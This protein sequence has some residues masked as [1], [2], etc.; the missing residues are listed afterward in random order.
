MFTRVFL[1]VA[2]AAVVGCSSDS[3]TTTPTNGT[4]TET[5]STQTPST[6]TPATQT[7]A[8]ETPATETP[9]TETPATETPATETPNTETPVTVTPSNQGPVNDS[10]AGLWTG[11][12]T[13]G[14]AVFVI[15][16]ADNVWGLSVNTAGRYESVY[17]NLSDNAPEQLY[18][19]RDSDDTDFGD[20][21]TGVGDVGDTR[22]YMF[23]VSNDGQS[24]VSSTEG[25]AFSLTRADNNDAAPITLAGI[26][27]EWDSRVAI[28]VDAD[29][30]NVLQINMTFAADGGVTGFSKFATP[31][32][33]ATTDG[34]AIL[35]SAESQGQYLT[36][37]FDWNGTTRTGIVFGDR[38]TDKLILQTSNPAPADGAVA[39]TFNARLTRQ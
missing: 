34:I 18:A 30:C 23:T 38:T 15:D 7:P 9:A 37:S 27:G 16:D 31:D 29:N 20:S 10:T 33:L 12:T 39:E 24:L 5:P 36:I 28:C 8:T 4:T 17:G 22:D 3:N 2:V 21:F 14:D 35:G 11:S 32:D 25:D 13:F 19:H 6:Q 1:A 26:A